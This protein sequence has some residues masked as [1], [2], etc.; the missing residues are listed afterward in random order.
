VLQE[1]CFQIL[2]SPKTVKVDVRVL[3]ATNR[4]LAKEVREGRFR[5][6]LYYRLHVFPIEVPPLRNRKEDIPMLVW[7]FVERFSREMRKEIRRIPKETM[8]ALVHYHWPGNVRELKNLIEQ[9]F[10]VS[11]GDLLTVRLP[12]AGDLGVVPARTLEGVERQHILSVLNQT[13]WRI[14]G[15]RGAAELLGLKPSTLYS[16]MSR[17][18]IPTKH[19]KD[20][21]ST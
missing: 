14:K 4:D 9:A 17:L 13:Q 7:N 12:D 5:E 8:E 6:D 20:D 19:K 21:I 16:T 15:P 3:A 18:G 1:G 10:I 11:Q 2:G